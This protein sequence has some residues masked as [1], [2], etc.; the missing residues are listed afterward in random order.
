MEV[1]TL[2]HVSDSD[3]TRPTTFLIALQ[4]LVYVAGYKHSQPPCV[5]LAASLR[6]T[7]TL[8]GIGKLRPLRQHRGNVCLPSLNH[9][10]R[11]VYNTLL[12][13]TTVQAIDTID[14]FVDRLDQRK[15]GARQIVADLS[16]H[17][18]RPSEIPA[19]LRRLKRQ[20]R[21]GLAYLCSP[22]TRS[23]FKGL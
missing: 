17:S 4:H 23:L 1:S 14:A 8:A 20:S 2:L 9:L 16:R 18:A 12:I 13:E 22:E 21:P 5:E 7:D 3:R 6:Q 11:D 15:R 10:F 19:F